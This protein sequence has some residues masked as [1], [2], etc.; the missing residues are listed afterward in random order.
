M[1]N[2]RAFLIGEDGHFRAVH[3][4]EGCVTD[5]QAIAAARQYLDGYGVEV[6]NLEQLIARLLPPEADNPSSHVPFL[7]FKE[8]Q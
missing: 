2:Y 5:E 8:L 6:W 4:L 1:A 3:L 7:D